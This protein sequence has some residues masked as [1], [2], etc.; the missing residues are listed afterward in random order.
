M[1]FMLA[2]MNFMLA[3]NHLMA[4]PTDALQSMQACGNNN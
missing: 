3:K 1:N 4:I 2:N